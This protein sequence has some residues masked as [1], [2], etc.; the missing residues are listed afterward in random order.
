MQTPTEARS[1]DT[2]LQAATRG[3]KPTPTTT[4]MVL[5]TDLTPVVQAVAAADAR[6]AVQE[7]M[8]EVLA[9]GID[10]GRLEAL[11]FVAT[12][13]NS[14][15]L[16]IYENVKKS[17][18]WRFLRNP[19]SS[20]GSNFESLEEFCA[21]KLGKTYGRL[22]HLLANRNLVGQEAFEQAERLGLR[23]VDYNAIKA[24]P[25]PDQ[26]LVRRAV[27]EA[28]SRDEVL[29]LLQELAARHAKEKAALS[30]QVDDATAKLAAKDK[31]LADNSTK[32]NEQ[33]QALE[34][35]RSAKF[36]PP[37]RS[38]ARTREE[39]A[40]LTAITQS[41]GRAYLRMHAVF[42]AAD[43]ALS[44][45]N[46][47]TP[48]AIQQVARQSIEFLVQQLADMAQ[49]FGISVDME[50]RIRPDWL[51]EEALAVLEARNAAAQ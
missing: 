14:A 9:A 37:P 1:I 46:G 51:D 30:A 22:Q 28:Q 45:I 38:V 18:A 24:L 25:A 41:T 35:A 44:D 29:D 3:R 27:E 6:M 13:A 10:L 50:S 23:Q 49:E 2:A 5:E 48:E 16:P 33:A 40:L 8:D 21:V 32:I 15:V 31:V 17:K 11:D 39:Q 20:N 12:V 26:E 7:E 4:P 34:M 36:T 47:N 42:T 19:K 43:A